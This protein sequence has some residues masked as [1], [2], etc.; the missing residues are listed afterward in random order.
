M[1][2]GARGYNGGIPLPPTP[3]QI[4]DNVASNIQG[5]LS[6]SSGKYVSGARTIVRIN[7]RLA[8]F[9]MSVTWNV[10]LSQDEI[11]TIDEYAPYEYAPK[12]II[13]DGTISGLYLPTNG[14]PTK[15]LFQANALSFLFQKY[16]TI[17]VKDRKTDAVLFKTTKAVITSSSGSIQAEQLAGLTLHWKAIGWQ[18]EMEPAL[19]SDVS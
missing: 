7:G 3:G 18:D 10:N 2:F 1:K 6:T 15:L 5:M 17:E 12:R 11:N 9:A 4:T 13:V 8:A 16:I 19:P 14:S